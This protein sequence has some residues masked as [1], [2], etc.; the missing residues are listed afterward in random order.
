[1]DKGKFLFRNGTDY[2]NNG[3]RYDKAHVLLTKAYEGAVK[4][5][6]DKITLAQISLWDGIS[7][8]ENMDIVNYVERNDKAIALYK[9]GLNYLTYLRDPRVIPI[10]MSLFNSLGVA[11]HHRNAQKEIQPISHYYYKRARKLYREHPEMHNT[12]N[13]IMKKVESNTGGEVL[14]GGS[15]CPSMPQYGGGNIVIID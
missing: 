7:V 4:A 1:M 2:V 8:Q 10:R 13:K 15:V 12:L 3:H 6:V 9:R 5:D 11:Y 14:R